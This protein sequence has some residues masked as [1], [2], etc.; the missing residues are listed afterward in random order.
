M[1]FVLDREKEKARKNPQRGDGPLQPS[2]SHWSFPLALGRRFLRPVHCP[3]SWVWGS[4]DTV[5][6][7]G[8]SSLTVRPRTD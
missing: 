4:D 6:H 7:V 1:A 5:G 3:C 8:S 2:L